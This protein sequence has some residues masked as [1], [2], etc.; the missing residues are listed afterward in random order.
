M[1]CKRLTKHLCN[2][3]SSWTN[4]FRL[5][6]RIW[7]NEYPKEP[8]WTLSW[9]EKT[10]MSSLVLVRAF[11]LNQLKGLLIGKETRTQFSEL[12]VVAW[13]FVLTA[14]LFYPFTSVFYPIIIFYRLI[15]GFNYRMC[16][17]FVDRYDEKWSLRSQNR[18]MMLL[19]I[20]Y[21]E[22][23]ISFAALYIWSGSITA[24]NEIISE[25]GNA[26]YFSI[27]TITTLGYGDFK[28]MDGLGRFLTSFETIMG[29][30][31]LVLVV[32]TFIGGIPRLSKGEKGNK[33]EQPE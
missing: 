15:E 4:E 1:C 5:V 12:Y 16:I 17:V 14:F 9:L 28:P 18:S 25:A 2:L 8:E 6:G 11:G 27:V 33:K 29:V 22:M 30:L 10:V 24:K 31:F 23:I 3:R 20:N 32:A 21:F 7:K 13:F 19:M 26:I